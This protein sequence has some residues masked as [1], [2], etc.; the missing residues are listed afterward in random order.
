MFATQAAPK[1]MNYERSRTGLRGPRQGPS[2]PPAPLPPPPARPHPSQA[3]VD[4][5]RTEPRRLARGLPPAEQLSRDAGPDQPSLLPS[6]PPGPFGAG[7]RGSG[8]GR[9]GPSRTHPS[10][11][12]THLI[13]CICPRWRRR[14]CAAVTARG[15]GRGRTEWSRAVQTRAER[16]GAEPC[17]G[18]RARVARRPRPRR[19]PGARRGSAA[20]GGTEKRRP[21]PVKEAAGAAR[22][23]LPHW[24]PPARG[25]S[26]KTWLRCSCT[27]HRHL[28]RAAE[29]QRWSSKNPA[30]RCLLAPPSSPRYPAG[31]RG[32]HSSGPV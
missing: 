18:G 24:G 1:F 3:L 12:T 16:S 32:A 11:T 10:P 4:P 20:G 13:A 19:S 23:R 15:V 2:L 27:V 25:Q 17:T 6:A 8:R 9:D 31:N 26:F 30:G 22:G 29:E 28:P 7:L 5:G 14:D 21:R